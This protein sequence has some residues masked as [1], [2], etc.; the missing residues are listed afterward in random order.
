MENE[1]LPCCSP[2]SPLPSPRPPSPVGDTVKVLVSPTNELLA[3]LALTPPLRVCCPH[4]LT[5]FSGMLPYWEIPL[6]T[7]TRRVNAW[8]ESFSFSLR[9]W[10]FEGKQMWTYY[11]L[12]WQVGRSKMINAYLEAE[13]TE[14]WKLKAKWF[15]TILQRVLKLPE[16]PQSL[17]LS[18]EEPEGRTLS[19]VP[20]F[21]QAATSHEK[22][23]LTGSDHIHL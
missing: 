22:T 10:V 18:I 3:W 4:G 11:L 6:V 12:F 21:K 13:G 23:I 8:L 20:H 15:K 14:S 7:Q 5:Q 17:P 1:Q 9:F 19:P 2:W 16:V